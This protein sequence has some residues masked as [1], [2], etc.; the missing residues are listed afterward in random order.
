MAFFLAEEDLKLRGPGD[1]FGKKQSGLPEFKVADVVHDYR[2]LETA[3]NDA[4]QILEEELL[5]SD[6]QYRPLLQYLEEEGVFSL[7]LD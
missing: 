2:A 6:I 7:K 3:R 1:F 5:I 4:S